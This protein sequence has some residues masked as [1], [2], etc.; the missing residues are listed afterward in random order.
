MVKIIVEKGSNKFMR[1]ILI[2][3]LLLLLILCAGCTANN[4]GIS[5][6][7]TLSKEKPLNS[8]L[9][10]DKEF[11]IGGKAILGLKYENI[12][13]IWG[14]PKEIKKIKVHFPATV[15]ESYSYILKYDSIDIEMYPVENNITI[16]STTSFRFDITGNKYDFYG[17]KIGMSLEEYL[18]RVENKDVFSVKEILSYSKSDN[19]PYPCVYKTL[20]TSVKEDNYYLNYD[21]AIYEQ[22]VLNDVPYG[23][24]MLFKNNIIERIV[25]GY[26][27]AS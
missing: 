18:N 7:P 1:K 19:F 10:R 17:I 20:L 8:R 24:V 23:A 15:E 2:A 26:P 14:K 12:I 11:L 5:S 21:K 13:K 9:I 25:Y 4:K 6:E 27:N 22:V 16:D 3:F